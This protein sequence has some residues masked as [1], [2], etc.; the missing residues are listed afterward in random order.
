MTAAA[1]DKLRKTPEKIV[2]FNRKVEKAIRAKEVDHALV[3]TLATR[4][5]EF[6]RKLDFMLRNGGADCVLPKLLDIVGGIQTKTLFE[7]V[8][9][10]KHRKATVGGQRQRIFVPKG[11]INKMQ[12][13]E[14]RRKDIDS[15]VIDMTIATLESELSQRFAKLPAQGKVYLDPGLKE[16]VV[17]T[18]VG[19]IQAPR[20]RSSKVRAISSARAQRSF[21]CSPI[22]SV[23]PT[24]TCR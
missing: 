3:E 24:L 7:I 5:G 17:P 4:P 9:Y 21:A 23:V 22:G 16:I 15:N 8:K 18:T 20:S 19:A 10:L 13:R 14:D 1:F 2:T 11:A 12:V 6:A